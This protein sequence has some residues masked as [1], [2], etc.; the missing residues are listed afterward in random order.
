M[1]ST[2]PVPNYAATTGGHALR[3]SDEC[4]DFK[5]ATQPLVQGH[6]TTS[7]FERSISIGQQIEATLVSDKPDNILDKSI[8][9]A[10]H[11]IMPKVYSKV[12]KRSGLPITG[13][14]R[15]H[16]QYEIDLV[17]CSLRFL[18]VVVRC[19]AHRNVHCPLLNTDQDIKTGSLQHAA[20]CL[21]C[22]HVFGQSIIIR[23]C[24]P[25][26]LYYISER[27]YG[28]RDRSHLESQTN[29]CRQL[30][31]PETKRQIYHRFKLVK[32]QKPRVK[33]SKVSTSTPVA[34]VGDVTPLTILPVNDSTESNGSPLTA[35]IGR[36][37]LAPPSCQRLISVDDSPAQA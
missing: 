27:V 4:D 26:P 12:N 28:C 20:E 29:V 13:T 8:S 19:L 33:R 22:H 21:V 6:A 11:C 7:A 18:T 17:V 24:S 14:L 10:L 5:F 25:I 30:L 15:S 23:S 35:S 1:S 36:V 32:F 2:I 9:E 37:S 31:W 3:R 34:T 16:P